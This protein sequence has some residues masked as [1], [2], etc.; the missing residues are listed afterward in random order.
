MTRLQCCLFVRHPTGGLK[1]SWLAQSLERRNG[2]AAISKSVANNAPD[3]DVDLK[4]TGRLQEASV[5]TTGM[6]VVQLSVR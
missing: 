2:Q 4:A 6:Y 5:K 1:S 3:G